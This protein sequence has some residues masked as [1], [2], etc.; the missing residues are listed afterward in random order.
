MKKEEDS[1]VKA[2]AEIEA[3][4]EEAEQHTQAVQPETVKAFHSGME[5]AFDEAITILKG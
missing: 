5:T 2:I 4:K 1:I 3:L